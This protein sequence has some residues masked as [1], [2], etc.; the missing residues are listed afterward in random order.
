MGAGD[1]EQRRRRRDFSVSPM[2]ALDCVELGHGTLAKE[3]RVEQVSRGMQSPWSDRLR[4][5]GR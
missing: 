5:T 1:Q 2:A 3:V 4:T